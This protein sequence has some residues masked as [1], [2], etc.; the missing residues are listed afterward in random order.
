MSFSQLRC[1]WGKIL[2][3]EI[4]PEIENRVLEILV[5]RVSELCKR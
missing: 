1:G 5:G 2:G 3:L 4:E